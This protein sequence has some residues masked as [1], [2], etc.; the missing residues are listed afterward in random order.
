MRLKIKDCKRRFIKRNFYSL[1]MI[2]E[3]KVE[4]FLPLTQCHEL[5]RNQR[6]S[7]NS[8]AL[9]K[10]RVYNVSHI[11]LSSHTKHFFISFKYRVN[12]FF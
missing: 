10:H 7:R 5:L 3:I 1:F 9:I 12:I 4:K 8:Q 6:C 2:Y 11:N